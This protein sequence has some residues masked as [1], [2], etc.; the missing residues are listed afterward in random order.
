VS[1]EKFSKCGEGKKISVEFRVFGR[2]MKSGRKVPGKVKMFLDE[3][4]K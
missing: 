3:N 2:K 1:E 4:L